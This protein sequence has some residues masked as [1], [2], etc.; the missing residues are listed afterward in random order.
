MTFRTIAACALI[1]DP[2][3]SAEAPVYWDVTGF[4]AC[5]GSGDPLLKVQKRQQCGGHRCGTD[6]GL[7][8][9]HRV[10]LWVWV[11]LINCVLGG[12]GWC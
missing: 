4:S 6:R 1:G 10:V 9:L 2:I 3:V 5:E 12:G 7:L 11:F 8:K